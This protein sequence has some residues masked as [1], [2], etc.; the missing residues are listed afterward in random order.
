MLLNEITL[1]FLFNA[2]RGLNWSVR[3]AIIITK[4]NIHR[5]CHIKKITL[6]FLSLCVLV[7]IFCQWVRSVSL[8]PPCG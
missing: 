2:S 6:K 3:A 1:E 7:C 4:L 5:L 8:L